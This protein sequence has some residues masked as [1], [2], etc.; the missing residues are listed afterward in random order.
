MATW[1][2]A[3]ADFASSND[4]TVLLSTGSQPLIK[5]IA[6]AAASTSLDPRTKVLA[7]RLDRLVSGLPA[8]RGCR[9]DA[10]SLLLPTPPAAKEAFSG[11]RASVGSL[12]FD[13]EIES[14]ALAL[15]ASR[16]L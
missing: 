13:L 15:M 2:E 14:V 8:P 7:D 10:A 12:G 3:V 16:I 6:K 9:V 1:N 5:G 11:A 4:R